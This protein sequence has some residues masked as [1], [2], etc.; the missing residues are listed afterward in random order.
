MANADGLAQFERQ[1][2][3]ERG[4][5]ATMAQGQAAPY[6]EELI[7]VK[8]G[9]MANMVRGRKIDYDMLIALAGGIAALQD[10]HTTLESAQR[11]GDAAAD[12]E[13]GDGT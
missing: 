5:Q 2:K 10:L 3:M 7:A 6:I 9:D 12:M 8:V 1:E 13:L 4:R 11:Q